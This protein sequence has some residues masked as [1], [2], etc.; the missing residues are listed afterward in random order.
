MNWG[1]QLPSEGTERMI[2]GKIRAKSCY[3]CFFNLYSKLTSVMG[4]SNYSYIW[5][6]ANDL[7]NSTTNPLNKLTTTA[8]KG[9]S[10]LYTPIWSYIVTFT[11]G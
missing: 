7:H 8:V 5:R 11:G 9:K 1:T 2:W 10:V 3:C 6:T 4:K